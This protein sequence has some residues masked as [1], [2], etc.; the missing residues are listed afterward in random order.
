MLQVRY[1]TRTLTVL[2]KMV[3]HV[4]QFPLDF[5]QAQDVAF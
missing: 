1:P 2:P 3:V 4:L 5:E